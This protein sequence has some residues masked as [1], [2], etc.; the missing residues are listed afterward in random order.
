MKR[1]KIEVIYGPMF[2]GKCHG[3][4]TMILMY[5]GEIKPVEEIMEGEVLM[6]DDSNPRKVLSLTKGP[7]GFVDISPQFG[8]PYRVNDVHVLSLKCCKDLS[9]IVFDSNN[10]GFLVTWLKN[11]EIQWK[12]F[13][14]QQYQTKEN[15][16]MAASQ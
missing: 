1:G 3:K 5:N 13:S 11:H 14:I 2:S 7:G 6:G 12:I 16:Q 4:G 8:E 9:S 15:A 10:N